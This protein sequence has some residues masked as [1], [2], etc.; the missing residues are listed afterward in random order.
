MRLVDAVLNA[1][2][3][4]RHTG[5]VRLILSVVSVLFV[6]LIL[7]GCVSGVGSGHSH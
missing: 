6:L 4:S 2:A 3:R 1:L 5:R 7:S